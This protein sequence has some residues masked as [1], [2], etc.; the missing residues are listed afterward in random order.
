MTEKTK[1]HV[2]LDLETMGTGVRPAITS[3]GACAFTYREVVDTF[4]VNVDLE[5]NY[6]LLCEP[7]TVKW[8][9][10]QDRAAID[11][12]LSDA[13]DLRDALGAFSYWLPE[14]APLWG[15]GCGFD[16]RILR[17]AYEAAGLNCSWSFRQDRDLRT[18][19]EL[20]GKPDPMPERDGTHH[21]SLDD[22]IYQ[23]GCMILV[24]GF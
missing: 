20:R 9:L 6:G 10:R 17:T 22:A 13:L 4:K 8:W 18:F 11:A 21:D 24:G 7:A 15:N 16:N 23:A 3:I 12:M 19:Y 14:G 5:S 2:M 1:L